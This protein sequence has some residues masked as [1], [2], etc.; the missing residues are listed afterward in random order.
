MRIL[1]ISMITLL[2]VPGVWASVEDD[3]ECSMAAAP[4]SPALPPD[5]GILVDMG[6]E[7]DRSFGDRIWIAAE[8]KR[9]EEMSLP[10]GSFA[11]EVLS[12]ASKGY[13]MLFRRLPS[14]DLSTRFLG[15]LYPGHSYRYWFSA[16]AP[17]THEIW[18][19][20]GWHESNRILFHVGDDDLP[21]TAL[22]WTSSPTR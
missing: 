1:L 8:G 6:C 4:P 15:C 7:D 13:A 11:I 5:L 21:L 9:S 16:D 2:V 14:G 20:I 10:L 12:P 22:T 19:R 17:G 18:Y 3:L